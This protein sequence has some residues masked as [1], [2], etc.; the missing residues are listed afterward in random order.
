MTALSLKVMFHKVNSNISTSSVSVNQ[1]YL[2]VAAVE[3][4]ELVD[5]LG[6]RTI[7][8]NPSV[9]SGGTRLL[10]SVYAC[11]FFHTE[12]NLARLLLLYHLLSLQF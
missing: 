8:L 7:Y 3:K 2:L 10:A 4:R 12:E 1:D 6:A 5:K 9:R 11:A